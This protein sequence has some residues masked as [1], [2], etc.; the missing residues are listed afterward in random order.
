MTGP[1]Y[2][3]EDGNA[4]SLME[5]AAKFYDVQARIVEKSVVW[6][7]GRLVHL[8]TMYHG[9]VDHEVGAHLYGTARIDVATGGIVEVGLWDS[10]PA[11][12]DGHAKLL[13]AVDETHVDEG[14]R[15]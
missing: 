11:A 7:D 9:F 2:F 1:Y 8:V 13:H 4:I 6:Q 15:E 3:N 10:R 5:W 14:T 12:I